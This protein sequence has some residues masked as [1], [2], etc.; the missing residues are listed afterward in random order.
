MDGWM[1]C[2]LREGGME[3]VRMGGWVDRGGREGGRVSGWV[4]CGWIDGWMDGWMDGL[5]GLHLLGKLTG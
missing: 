1:A 5:Y 4:D 2:G 3:G